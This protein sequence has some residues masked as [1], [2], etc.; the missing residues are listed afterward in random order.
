MPNEI[1]IIDSDALIKPFRFFYPFDM[2]PDICK[3]FNV[4]CN[5][6]YYMMRKLGFRASAPW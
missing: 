4:N 6:L 2:F 1:F 3:Q 5:D